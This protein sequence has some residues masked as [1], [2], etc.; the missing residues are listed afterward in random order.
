MGDDEG[1]VE[2]AELVDNDER[3]RV[4]LLEWVLKE[5]LSAFL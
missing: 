5:F 3:V 4:V 1:H 2:A